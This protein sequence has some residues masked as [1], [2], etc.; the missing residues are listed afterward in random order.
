MW[1]NADPISAHKYKAP[2]SSRYPRKTRIDQFISLDAS[3]YLVYHL[4]GLPL[5][6]DEY[7]W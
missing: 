6:V 4:G 7:S 5:V 2:M 3:I 1:N